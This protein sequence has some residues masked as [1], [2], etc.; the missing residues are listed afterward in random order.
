[1]YYSMV[2]STK[3]HSRNFKDKNLAIKFYTLRSSIYVK[4]KSKL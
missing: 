4:K 1:M 2:L 3:Y